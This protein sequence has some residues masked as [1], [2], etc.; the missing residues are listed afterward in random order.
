MG[1]WRWVY[2]H[3]RDDRFLVK[4]LKRDGK[5]S[6]ARSRW[7]Q[8]PAREGGYLL[9]S[10]EI[11]EFIAAEANSNGGPLPIPRIPGFVET[12]L[13]LGLI[14]EK[15]SGRSGKLAPKLVAILR[16]HGFTPDIQKMLVALTEQINRHRIILHDFKTSN[17][18][19]AENDTGQRRLVLVDGFGESALVPI[20]SLSATA[21]AR[22]N[23]RKYRRL[24]WRIDN[25]LRA[26]N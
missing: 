5:D 8:R 22:R 2:Q 26:A 12:D 10:R 17:I 11:R 7:Y 24:L 18:V 20:F 23:W 16:Q 21:N 15:I 4:V 19:C 3:P 9:F 1:T 13:G 25:Y 6:L 14:V